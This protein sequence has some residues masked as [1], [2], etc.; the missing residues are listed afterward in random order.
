MNRARPLLAP[1]ALAGAALASGKVATTVGRRLIDA[2]PTRLGEVVIVAVA[3]GVT[4]LYNRVRIPTSTIQLLVGSVAGVA[5]GAS[6]GVHWRTIGT[7]VVVWVAAP[8]AA[9]AI[10]FG[11][12]KALAHVTR[13][14]GAL[15]AVG[16]LAS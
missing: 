6:A 16:C 14:G 9:A 13:V 2:T 3:F 15:V 5:V 12:T 11:A 4:A 1:L 7:L 10:G 8:L